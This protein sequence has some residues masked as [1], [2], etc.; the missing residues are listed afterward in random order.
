[1]LHV[2]SPALFTLLA[3]LSILRGMI[4][5]EQ[6]MVDKVSQLE[7]RLYQMD[8]EFEVQSGRLKKKW[9]ETLR[10]EL[11]R[12]RQ[13]VKEEYQF[14]LD[15]KVQEERSKMLGEKLNLLGSINGEKDVELVNLRLQQSQVKKA[16]EKLEQALED[17][18]RELDRVL[19]L[20]DQKNW[21][22]F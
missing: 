8:Q 16:N 5:M 1:M 3:Y 20:K 7:D 10:Q 13:K 11:E 21:W 4:Q 17:S 2:S 14:T 12:V 15:I 22:P 6:E 19:A 9:D 18:K